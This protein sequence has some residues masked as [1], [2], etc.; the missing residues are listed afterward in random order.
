MATL[1]AK[2]AESLEVLNALR[3]QSLVAIRSSALKR[4]H[5]ERLLKNGYLLEVMKGWYIAARPD[6]GGESAAWQAAFWLFWADYLR[7]R[8]GRDWCL[9]PGHSLSLHAGNRAIPPQLLVYAP[10]GGNKATVLPCGTSLFD[11]RAALPAAKDIEE[12]DGLRLFALPAAL[13]AVSP[14]FFASHAADGRAALAAIDDI[15]K[16]PDRLLAGGRSTIAG[17]LAGAFRNIGRAR[18]ADEI[19]KSMRSAGHAVREQDPFA[20]EMKPILPRPRASSHANRIRRLWQRMRGTIIEKFPLAPG[21][22]P[23]IDGYLGQVRDGYVTD[24]YHS[25]SLEGYRVSPALIERL[26]L[27]GL[28]PSAEPPDGENG[29]APAAQGYRLAFQAVGESLERVLHG[30]NP[31]LVVAEDL[32]IW[33]REMFAPSVAGGSPRTA[34]PAPGPAGDRNPAAVIRGTL[35]PPSEVDAVR[36]GLPVFFEMLKAEAEPSVRMVL[37][38]CLFVHL[39]P[40]PAG[41]GRLG[42]FIM[43]VMAAAGGY[44]WTVVPL[45]RQNDYMAALEEAGVRQDIGPFADL[46][47]RLVAGGLRG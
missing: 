9:S 19:L 4:V 21:R 32:T 36:E 41:N 2:L 35:P 17:R 27:N 5:R 22:A 15:S 3:Q 24:A 7:E 44:P 37:G 26:R 20:G 23:D 14:G 47:A 40:Y 6:A 25:L 12:K 28:D 29:D 42:R 8:F 43:N 34:G 46:L 38:H 45:W 1:Q 13:L 30:E 39:H 31:G 10:R 33:Y 11:V 16:I 18:L